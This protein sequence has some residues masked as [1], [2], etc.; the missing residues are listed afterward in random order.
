MGDET[1]ATKAKAPEPKAA[2]PKDDTVYS[3]NELIEGHKAFDRPKECV[4]AAL[5]YAGIKMATV[6]D[7]RAIIDR[8]MRKVIK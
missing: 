4:A 8:F 1:K 7:A 3:L 6:D 5:R 2:A